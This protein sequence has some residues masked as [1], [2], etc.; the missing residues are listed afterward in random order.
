[1]QIIPEFAPLCTMDMVEVPTTQSVKLRSVGLSLPLRRMCFA[2]RM[3][4]S[5]TAVL[6]M[7]YICG[8]AAGWDWFGGLGACP[9]IKNL[10]I[11]C[12]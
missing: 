6:A 2:S 9:Q 5:S 10:C 8:F 7:F 4:S 11:L 3:H 12:G 1:M